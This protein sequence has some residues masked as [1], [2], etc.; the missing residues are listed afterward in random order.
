MKKILTILLTVLMAF[1]V[2][3]V[4]VT[5]DVTETENVEETNDEVLDEVVPILEQIEENKT[6]V[7]ETEV[8]EAK[9][10]GEENGTKYNITFNAN[11]GK[12]DSKDYI[13]I[14]TN[15]SG[16]INQPPSD[17]RLTPP[18]DNKKFDGW[19]TSV[20]GN[21]AVNFDNEFTSNATIY[22][23]WVDKTP[24]PGPEPEETTVTVT[25]EPNGGSFTDDFENKTDVTRVYTIGNIYGSFSTV[26]KTGNK[27]AGWYNGG[28]Q[29]T[30]DT[31]VDA[32]ITVLTA[33]WTPITVTFNAS[34]NGGKI[35][36]QDYVTIN[37]NDSNGKIVFPNND[38]VKENCSFDGWYDQETGGSEIDKNTKPN[39]N[40]ILYAHYSE[41]PKVTFDANGGAFADSSTTKVAYANDK[42]VTEPADP[43][44]KNSS[45]DGWYTEAGTKFNKNNVE[46]SMTVYAHWV[47]YEEIEKPTPI[48]ELVYTGKQQD[49]FNSIDNSNI[50]YVGTIKAT[51]AGSYTVTFSLKKENTVWKDDT[52]NDISDNTSDPI[53]ITWTIARKVVSKDDIKLSK[54]EFIYN[55][56]VQKPEVSV[57]GLKGTGANAEY[58]VEFVGDDFINAGIKWVMVTLNDNYEFKRPNTETSLEAPEVY[59]VAFVTYEIKPAHLVALI[60]RDDKELT[61]NGKQQKPVVTVYYTN[62]DLKGKTLS[63]VAYNL[64]YTNAERGFRYDVTNVGEKQITISLYSDRNYYFTTMSGRHVSRTNIGYEIVPKEVTIVW[65]SKVKFVRNSKEHAPFVAEVVGIV[66]ADELVNLTIDKDAEGANILGIDYVEGKGRQLHTGKYT[67]EVELVGYKAKNYVIVGGNSI[68]FKIY[69][70]SNDD[71]TPVKTGVDR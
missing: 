1:T 50:N 58:T 63:S 51:D 44:K 20:D 66:D 15:G 64:T 68:D 24:E 25:F 19:Y 43:T 57:A 71:T 54:D 70:K 61:Y 48:G 2:V 18:G 26:T 16:K 17:G 47:D 21:T 9:E 28:T 8:L 46:E 52:P 12:I 13:V 33:N 6:E 60:D 67:A 22:A 14:Q 49:G 55:G 56:K 45:F 7:L 59:S 35:D 4:N 34:A 11:G 69:R 10:G 36:G 29:I 23:H 30:E 37:I 39:D 62:G 53:E 65:D 27:F 41:N 3:T 42:K 38:P 5:A 32:S 40:L 31:T